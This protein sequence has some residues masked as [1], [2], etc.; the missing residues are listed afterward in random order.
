MTV[1]TAVITLGAAAVAKTITVGN[2]TGAS[3]LALKTGTGDFTL[4]S[5]TGTIISALDTGEV[6]MALQSA[7]LATN[8]ANQLNITGDGTAAT[9]EFATE[10][11]DQN[12]DYATPN[13]TAPITGRYRIEASVYMQGL[14]STHTSG[15][16]RMTTSN[17]NYYSNACN[18]YVC[19]TSYVDFIMSGSTLCDM[20][21]ADTVN[22]ALVIQLGT[23]VVD[24]AATTTGSWFSVQLEC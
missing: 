14:L 2:T 11:F 12:A 24:A 23:K 17:R 8:D 6:T 22:I 5:A 16:L 9:I 4:A 15:Y 21:A 19:M 7:F 1:T 10:I 13:F 20:D 18:P 3:V